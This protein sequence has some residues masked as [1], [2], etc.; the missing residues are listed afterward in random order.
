VRLAHEIAAFPQTCLREDR[1]SVLEQEGRSTEEAMANE[2][3]HG[4]VSLSADTL[5]GAR[6]FAGGAGRH[7]SFGDD[8]R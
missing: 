8:G 3:R 5:S 4:V 1:M 2:F 6:R 7:G